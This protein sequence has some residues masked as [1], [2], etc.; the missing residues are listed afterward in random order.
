MVRPSWMDPGYSLAVSESSV[1]EVQIGAGDT[2][3]MAPR[4]PN[5][6]AVGI[7]VSSNGGFPVAGNVYFA[8]EGMPAEDGIALSATNG[9]QWFT[10]FTHG[11]F[12]CGE[13]SVFSSVGQTV[14]VFEVQING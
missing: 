7:I 5:R 9:I 8:P 13:W 14:Y 10:L 12:V 4:N 6:Y 3:Q 1:R 11:A 2:V